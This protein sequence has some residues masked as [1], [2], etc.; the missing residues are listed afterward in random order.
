M[1]PASDVMRDLALSGLT[2]DQLALVMELSASLGGEVRRDPVAEK[3]RAYDR[4]RKRK[5]TGIPPESTEL[6]SPKEYISNPHPVT[7]SAKADTPLNDFPTRVVEGWN[8]E[9]AGTPLPKARPLTPDRRKHLAARVKE[10]GEDA[11]FV[12]I[13]NMAA[14]EFHS[15]KSGKWTEGNLGWLLKSPENFTKMLERSAPPAAKQPVPVEQTIQARQ[16]Q[17]RIYRRMGR[18]NEAD[19]LDRETERIRKAAGIGEI[20]HRITPPNQ[21]SDH[22]SH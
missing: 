15:G 6:V 19:A 20:L 14:S 17:A 5:S 2:V 21:A 18:E 7:P 8:T 1:R 3:R 4:E 9:T 12:A 10:H 16:D 22:G 13:R 11:V